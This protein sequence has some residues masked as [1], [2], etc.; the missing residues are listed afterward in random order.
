MLSGL[1]HRRLPAATFI[2]RQGGVAAADSGALAALAI[3]AAAGTGIAG[4]PLYM[5]SRLWERKETE[6][7]IAFIEIFRADAAARG[8][9]SST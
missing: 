3:L 8:G 7:G 4:R 1:T 6:R 5:E 9:A 2:G